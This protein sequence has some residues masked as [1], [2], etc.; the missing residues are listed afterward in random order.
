MPGRGGTL[1]MSDDVVLSTAAIQRAIDHM[2]EDHRDSLL[3][4]ARSLA[5]IAWAEEAELIALDARGLGIRA[6]GSGRSKLARVDFVTP[7]ESAQE[8]R[9]AVILLARRARGQ[10]V[11]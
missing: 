9:D 6:S 2:N 11:S 4:M 5:G 7:L 3:D 1:A 10:A 8:L